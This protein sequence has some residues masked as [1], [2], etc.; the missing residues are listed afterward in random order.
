MTLHSA[1][2][3]ALVKAKLQNSHNNLQGKYTV[4]LYKRLYAMPYNI[5]TQETFET[6]FSDSKQWNCFTLCCN[7]HICYI[8]Q[9]YEVA[10]SL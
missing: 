2:L 1:K 5:T 10:F 9:E 3:G 6:I 4:Y 7:L 8:L